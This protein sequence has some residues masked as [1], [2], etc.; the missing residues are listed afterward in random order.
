MKIC[1]LSPSFARHPADYAMSWLVIL[2]RNL[3]EREHQLEVFTSSY[4][5]LG[6]QEIFGLKIY[7]FRYW[8]AK[9]ENLTHEDTSSE[10][11]SKEF[12]TYVIIF[13]YILSGLL[14]SIIYF[15]K[16]RFDVIHIHCPFPQA[17]FAIIPKI[18][19]GSKLIYHFHGTEIFL[20]GKHPLVRFFFRPFMN[21]ADCIIANSSVTAQAVSMVFRNITDIKIIPFGPSIPGVQSSPQSSIYSKEDP[22]KLLFVGRLIERKGVR[23]L[24]DAMKILQDKNINA[25]LRIVGDG[26]Q[27]K[28]LEAQIKSLGLEFCISITGFLPAQS[29]AL[30]EEY[31]N[32]HIFVFPSIVD[33]KGNSEGLGIVA[34][35]AIFMGKPVVASS[36][37]GIKD[38][39]KDGDTGFLVSE[40]DSTAIAE[41]VI[42]IKNNYANALKIAQKA[43]KCMLENYSWNIVTEKFIKAYLSLF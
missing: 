15:F 26:H 37:G 7:R 29:Q 31:A 22:I 13:F 18:F 4:M 40:K 10:T 21:A 17:F 9:S 30:A 23:Y 5:G 11:L 32:C 43:R 34:V 35:D 25:N 6:H 27:R 36:I 1:F 14:H 39:I 20:L 42:F 28:D 12:S 19:H 2:A 8:F 33:S 16:K 41:K 38:L 24:V 3:M